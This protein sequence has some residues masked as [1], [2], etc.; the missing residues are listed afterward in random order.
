MNTRRADRW[1]L[2][3][4]SVLAIVTNPRVY[5]LWCDG[6]LPRMIWEL[7]RGASSPAAGDL[8]LDQR[9]FVELRLPRAILCLLVGACRAWAARSCR[10]CFGI[11]LSN[12]AW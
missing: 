11:R 2:V 10:R 7:P 8:T 3:L 1:C 6:L 12:P 9:I 5:P 4:L